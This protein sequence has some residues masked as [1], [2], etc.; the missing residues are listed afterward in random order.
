MWWE[1]LIKLQK[2]LFLA[3]WHNN[4]YILHTLVALYFISHKPEIINP[5]NRQKSDGKFHPNWSSLIAIANDK[6]FEFSCNIFFP[7]SETA[8]M[9]SLSQVKWCNGENFCSWKGKLFLSPSSLNIFHVALDIENFLLFFMSLVTR[10]RKIVRE[11]KKENSK[12]GMEI[13]SFSYVKITVKLFNKI[14]KKL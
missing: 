3:T 13:Y 11:R 9:A 7:R 2:F 5:Y 10:E 1:F 4:K 6:L 14:V 12:Q 8:F